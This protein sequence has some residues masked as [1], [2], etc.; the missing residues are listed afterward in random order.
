MIVGLGGREFDHEG[1]IIIAVVYRC[2]A[3]MM[4]V[5]AGGLD[6]RL[7]SPHLQARLLNE[8]WDA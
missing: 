4:R 1:A 7:L 3:S 2:D 8:N 6:Q 5:A